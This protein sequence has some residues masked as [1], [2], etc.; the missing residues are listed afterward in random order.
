[1]VIDLGAAAEGH[2]TVVERE[3]S[4]VRNAIGTVLLKVIIES[5]L[6]DDAGI[7]AA[8]RASAG[9]GCRLR[10]DL[11]RLPSKRRR[12]GRRGTADG[13]DRRRPTRREGQRRHPYGRGGPRECWI[14]GATRLGLSGTR[15]V[16]DGIAS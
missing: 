16:L 15:A 2:W 12:D 6:L 11:D 3:I 4:A 10:E 5:A 13:R 7:V 8:C 14:A 1:M 9:G